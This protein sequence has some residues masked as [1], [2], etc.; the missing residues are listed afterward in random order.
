MCDVWLKV[1]RVVEKHLWVFI[2]GAPLAIIYSY[3]YCLVEKILNTQQV[4]AL[5]L[6]G[7][8]VWA[9]FLANLNIK[10]FYQQSFAYEIVIANSLWGAIPLLGIGFALFTLCKIRHG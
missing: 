8:A 2:L 4:L 9:V 10:G 1:H 3:R 7:G 5:F 6:G